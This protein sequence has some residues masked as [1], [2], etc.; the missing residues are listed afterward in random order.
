MI[1]WNTF[2]VHACI[3]S[4]IVASPLLAQKQNKQA[5]AGASACS[6]QTDKPD[7]VKSALNA[8]TVAQLGGRPEDQQK[9]LKTAVGSLTQNPSKYKSNQAG[10]DY[11]LGQA[12]VRWAQQF[13]ESTTVNKGTMGYTD[14][15]DQ[16]IDP[17]AAADTLFSSAEK[18]NPDCAAEIASARLE[19]MRPLAIRA[20]G[21]LNADS[22]AQAEAVINRLKV[23]DNKSP[24]SLYFQGMVAQNKKDVTSAADYFSRGAAAMPAAAGAD[25]IL[26]AAIEFGGAMMSRLSAHSMTG[27]QN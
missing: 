17:L 22:M 20:S 2:T 18:S 11:V 25:R 4:A 10:H 7:E 8:L 24:L 27:Y 1:R 9:R 13:P 6:I 14:G 3:A 12:L 19:A 21:L 26:M 23:I 15:K 16:S 5:A